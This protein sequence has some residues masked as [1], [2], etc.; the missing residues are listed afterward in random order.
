[1]IHVATKSAGAI[2]NWFMFKSL[3]GLKIER[4]KRKAGKCIATLNI[5]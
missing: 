1:M 4:N 2:L 3:G 5:K